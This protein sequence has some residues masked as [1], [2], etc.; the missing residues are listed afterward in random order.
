MANGFLRYYYH[1][2]GAVGADD[3]LMRPVVGNGGM[4]AIGVD[5]Y[6]VCPV[7]YDGGCGTVRFVYDF[8]C[9]VVNN[10]C[11]VSIGIGGN[12]SIPFGGSIEQY[13]N[14]YTRGFWTPG[15][16]G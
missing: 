5:D 13:A 6:F 7:V 12:I 3:N 16:S 2:V 11:C 14:G 1:F 8:M 15:S 4:S 10:R 9:S